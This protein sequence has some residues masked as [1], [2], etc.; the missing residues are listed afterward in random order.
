MYMFENAFRRFDY[1]YAS[2]VS[3][4]LFML[5]LLGSL[6]NFVWLR[7]MGGTK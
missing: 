7:R 6:L 2:A 1:G 5:I 4:M 3:W